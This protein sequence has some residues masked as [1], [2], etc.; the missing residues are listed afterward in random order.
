MLEP[1][2]YVPWMLGAYLLGSLSVGDLVA[3]TA[4]VNIRTVGTGN[5]GAAN[6]YREI[7]RGHGIAVLVL[8][9]AKGAAATVPLLVLD[10]PSLARVLAGGGLLLGHFFPVFWRYH[11]STGLAAGM[12][13]TTGLIP[14]GVLIAGPLAMLTVY[15]TRKAG[16]AGLLFFAVTVPVGGLLHRDVVGALAVLAVGVAIIIRA[17]LQYGTWIRPRSDGQVQA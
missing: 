6:I 4:G 13:T 11:G 1:W 15:L 5:P 14:L 7:G 12:G 8:D 17:R 16:Y 2:L 10:E 3:R 9:V